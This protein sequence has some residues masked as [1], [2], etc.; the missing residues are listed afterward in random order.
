[1]SLADKTLRVANLTIAYNQ[2]GKG[3]DIVLLHGI[4][5]TSYIWRFLIPLLA[6]TGQFRVTSLDLPG[7]GRSSHNLDDRFGLDRQVETLAQV[8]QHLAIEQTI[9]VGSS[10]GGAIALWFARRFPGRTRC[11]VAIAPASSART[12]ARPLYWFRHF[13]WFLALAVNRLAIRFFMKQALSRHELVDEDAIAHY[14]EAYLSRFNQRKQAIRAFFVSSQ[15]LCD[16]RLPHDLSTVHAPVVILWGRDDRLV[17][18]SQMLELLQTLESQTP[19]PR[20]FVHENGGHHLM[21]D[22][23]DWVYSQIATR[24]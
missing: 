17:P 18:F 13:S 10:M 22:Q 6:A 7:F 24:L 15:I 14:S 12:I 21:E 1:M 5:A 11:V 4:G 19:K 2:T 20:L 3:R 16:R 8:L 23:P 9:L